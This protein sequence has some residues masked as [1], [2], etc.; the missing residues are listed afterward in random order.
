VDRRR[1]RFV[2]R[3]SRA[4]RRTPSRTSTSMR[5]VPCSGEYRTAFSISCRRAWRTRDRSQSRAADAGAEEIAIV[6][7]LVAADAGASLAA[8][9]RPGA[10][11][12][13]CRDA[14]ETEDHVMSRFVSIRRPVPHPLMAC[15]MLDVGMPT[16]GLSLTTT[17]TSGD[18]RAI[19]KLCDD[20]RESVTQTR[21]A[22]RTH[23]GSHQA[24]RSIGSVIESSTS[25]GRMARGSLERA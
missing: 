2:R 12:R 23:G 25:F 5:T 16:L 1:A 8:V 4:H 11:K 14:R 13:S 15:T 9:W 21:S 22:T 24:R 17:L 19:A 7:P 18:A 6:T 20:S 3:S 10:H